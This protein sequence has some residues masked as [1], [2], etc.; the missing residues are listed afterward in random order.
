MVFLFMYAAVFVFAVG[1][2]GRVLQYARAP[3]HLRWELYPVPHET[4]ERVK[5]GGSYFE[6]SGRKSAVRTWLEN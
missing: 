2:I 5:H 4:P 6:E 3:I 1:C